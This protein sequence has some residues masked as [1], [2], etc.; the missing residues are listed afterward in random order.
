MNIKLYNATISQLRGKAI[1]CLAVIESLLQDGAPVDET[2]VSKIMEH[3]LDLV[4][5][6]GAMHSLQQY[7]PP[8]PEAPTAP[9]PRPPSTE[10]PLVV[11]PEMSPTYK[12]SLEKQKI[13][14]SAKARSKKKKDE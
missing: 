3:A 9:P 14:D 13:K 1:E 2:T 7:F 12:K 11:T 5:Y 6:E 8:Q 10:P 4:Q